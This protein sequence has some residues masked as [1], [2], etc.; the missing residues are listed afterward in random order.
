MR[1]YLTLLALLAS[2]SGCVLLDDGLTGGRSREDCGRDGGAGSRGRTDST[3]RGTTVPD[4]TILFSAV[5][6]P[7][8]YDWQRDT[9]YGS[10]PF[11]LV[12]YRDFQPVLRLASG[13]QA[14][15][16]PD[17]DRHHLSG[18]H[19]YTERQ[20]DGQTVIGRDGQELF[21]FDG[22][23]HLAGLLEDGED[24]YTLSRPGPEAGFSFRK[25]GVLLLERPEGVLFGSLS[26]PSC[27]PGGALRRDGERISFCY[28]TG[29]RG[30]LS[31]FVVRDGVE[32]RLGDLPAEEILD[33]KAWNGQ[34]FALRKTVLRNRL[35]EGSLW[36]EGAGYAV[37]GR[38]L[39]DS[40]AL[41]TGYLEAAAWSVRHELCREE[42]WL[43]HT[44]QATFA[45]SAAADGTV[46]WYGPDG[47]GQTAEACHFLS[48]AC[49][50]ALGD[51]LLIA[52][53]P[54]DIRAKPQVRLGRQT[55]EVDIHGYVSS[56]GAE[57]SPAR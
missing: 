34:V 30:A 47:G 46:R 13:P 10:V 41:V 42:A 29:R 23:E 3:G 43:Y 2:L 38:F 51:R 28:R 53:T 57:I 37:T 18:G 21:R 12:L 35:Q 9:A 16:T 8:D 49:A 19:L 7:D 56:V 25:N 44:E 31:Y 33:M 27:G 50:T 45:V 1:T 20:L 32:T 55:R 39:D 48:P 54:R 15:F 17:P 26:D 52:L 36:P 22:R 5:R 11:E 14:C 24:L 40:G 6:F 4:T